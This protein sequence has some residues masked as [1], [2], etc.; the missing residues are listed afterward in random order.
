MKYIC[1][2]ALIFVL[3]SCKSARNDARET[4]NTHMAG[5]SADDISADCNEPFSNNDGDIIIGGKSYII[6]RFKIPNTDIGIYV[7]P[8]NRDYSINLSGIENYDIFE[9]ICIWGNNLEDVDFSPLFKLERLKSLYIFGGMSGNNY[10]TEIPY[11]KEIK[12]LEIFYVE[13]VLTS[14][15]DIASNLPNTLEGLYFNNGKLENIQE[16]SQFNNLK[17]LELP[18][19]NYNIYDLKGLDNLEYLGIGNPPQYTRLIGGEENIQL[20]DYRGI[21]YLSSLNR[22]DVYNPENN[23]E[24]IHINIESIGLL[25]GLKTLII[26]I[27]DEDLNFIKNIISLEHLE[28]NNYGN[29]KNLDIK[30]LNKMENLYIL[31]LTNFRVYNIEL[32]NN[33]N[34]LR[35]VS[36][37]CIFIPEGSE[38]NLNRK[39]FESDH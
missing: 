14:L 9:E 8:Y 27:K 28:I 21:E 15:N 5:S 16:L 11:L 22:L 6:N 32:L 30:I 13:S 10:L 12:N 17:S 4:I 35:H 29:I 23:K 2:L 34:Y 26:N 31:R 1:L 18:F 25:Q 33:F 19:G 39:F 20:V 37:D 7:D 38:R 24:N 36:L 3:F